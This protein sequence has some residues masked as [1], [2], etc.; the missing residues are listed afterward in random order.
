MWWGFS[1]PC[2][3]ISVPHKPQLNEQRG[4]FQGWE[5]E[6]FTSRSCVHL[7]ATAEF[8]DASENLRVTV[9]LVYLL[10]VRSGEMSPPSQDAVFR[11]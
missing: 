6:P 8:V 2:V 1:S 11:A 10:Q 5:T 9:S 7:A 3:I 4:A